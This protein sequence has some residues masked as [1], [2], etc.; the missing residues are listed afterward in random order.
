[1]RSEGK[2]EGEGPLLRGNPNNLKLIADDGQLIR[3]DSKID[4]AH[5]VDAVTWWNNFGREFGPKSPE[6]RKFM[7]DSGNYIFQPSSKNR[8]EGARLGQTY[9]P[10][11]VPGF[12]I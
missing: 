11:L 6:V 12:T 10:P 1:M 3:I 8:A 2:I 5:T 7:L 4:M 9:Q